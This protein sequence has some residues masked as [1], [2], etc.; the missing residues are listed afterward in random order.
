MTAAA[1]ARLRV[2]TSPLDQQAFPFR[3]AGLTVGLRKPDLLELRGRPHTIGLRFRVQRM[4][5][6]RIR[7]LQVTITVP[8]TSGSDAP[9]SLRLEVFG[10][11]ER[12][13]R[14]K[15]SG[16]GAERLAS[17]LRGA[18]LD[19]LVHTVDLTACTATWCPRQRHWRVCVEPYAGS[20]LRVFFPPINYSTTLGS[21]EAATIVAALDE[22]AGILASPT[23]RSTAKE[24]SHEP[25]HP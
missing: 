1:T 19:Q 14:W 2:R 23:D 3:Q 25:P 20:H 9:C 22:V 11:R 18:A 13:Y 21:N 16:L 6:A 17:W 15:V 24:S 10:S 12:T 5:L 8:V 4:L 7:Q